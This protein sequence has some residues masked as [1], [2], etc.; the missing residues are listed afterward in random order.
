MFTNNLASVLISQVKRYSSLAS[1]FIS[2]LF[3]KLQDDNM[4]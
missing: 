1:V 4:Y 3:V 2:S